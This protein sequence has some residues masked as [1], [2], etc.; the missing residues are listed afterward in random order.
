MLRKALQDVDLKAK[1]NGGTVDLF[2]AAPA[3]TATLF[4]QKSVDAAATQEPWGYILQNQAGGKLLLD[5]EDFA[6]GK[7]STNTVVATSDGFLQNKELVTAYLK[8]HARAVQF[9]RDEPEEAQALVVKH[10]KGLTGKELD[11]AELEAAFSR[12]E[13]TTEVNEDVLQEM[14]DISQEA[15]YIKTN[16]IDGLIDLNVIKEITA[17]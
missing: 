6:W 1:T 12:I 13:V 7:E 15:D 2:A 4:I 11:K 14:A 17:K 9:V 5:W 10:I 3:D 16:E 8:A